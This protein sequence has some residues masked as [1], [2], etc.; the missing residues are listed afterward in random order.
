MGKSHF[1]VHQ[2]VAGQ[3]PS[4]QKASPPYLKA[5]LS[6]CGSEVHAGFHDFW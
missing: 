2:L 1:Q 4:S 6:F 5:L 3:A